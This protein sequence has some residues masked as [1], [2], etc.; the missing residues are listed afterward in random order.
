MSKPQTLLTIEIGP[1]GVNRIVSRPRTIGQAAECSRLLCL[2]ALP[3]RLLHDSIRELSGDVSIAEDI[4]R[5]EVQTNRFE[6]NDA[7]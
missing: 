6:Q 3:V 7:S 4:P 2:N 1:A 5:V